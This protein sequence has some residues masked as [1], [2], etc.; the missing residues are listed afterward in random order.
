MG[1]DSPLNTPDCP[2]SELSQMLF[3]S[4][5]FQ[6]TSNEEFAHWTGGN[7]LIL[8]TAHRNRIRLNGQVEC[9]HLTRLLNYGCETMILPI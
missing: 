3:F 9:D 6:L 2:A 5:I 7:Q 1:A 4:G 8:T